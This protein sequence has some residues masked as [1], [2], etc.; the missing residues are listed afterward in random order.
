MTYYTATVIKTTWSWWKNR[1][2]DW[3]DRIRIQKNTQIYQ[4][5][6]DKTT[7]SI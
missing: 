4:I 1:H 2:R 7:N 5:I 6:F 3:G